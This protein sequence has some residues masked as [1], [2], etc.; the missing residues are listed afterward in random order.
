MCLVDGLQWISY[1]MCDIMQILKN[2]HL[3]KSVKYFFKCLSC[4]F[5]I[6]F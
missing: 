3:E 4:S 1:E 6:C 5:H 2:V